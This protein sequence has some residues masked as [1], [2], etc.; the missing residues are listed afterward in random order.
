MRILRNRYIYNR[1]AIISILKLF[2]Q[3]KNHNTS[4][5]ALTLEAQNMLYFA[6]LDPE[7]WG[8]TPLNKLKADI[9]KQMEAIERA[10]NDTVEP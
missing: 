5:A 6:N 10:S 2:L 1:T 8:I 9:L 3:T 7:D 4:D